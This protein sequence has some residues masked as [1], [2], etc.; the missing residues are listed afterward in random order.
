MRSR[1]VRGG[2]KRG[3]DYR[4]WEQC[5]VKKGVSVLPTWIWSRGQTWVG[6]GHDVSL[7]NAQFER[8]MRSPR[9]N[10]ESTAGYMGLINRKEFGQRENGSSVLCPWRHRE[11]NKQHRS[12]QR[13]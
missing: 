13:S 1:D 9:E 8:P 6:A 2:T 5:G 11:G 12:L 10:A 3:P 7:G 4:S